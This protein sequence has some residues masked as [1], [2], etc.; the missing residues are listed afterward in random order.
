MLNLE[1]SKH[2]GVPLNEHYR[3]ERCYAESIAAYEKLNRQGIQV[4]IGLPTAFVG[5][6][7]NGEPIELRHET[8][9][10]ED[11]LAHAE[12]VPKELEGSIAAA[13]AELINSKVAEFKKTCPCVSCRESREV[14]S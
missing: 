1:C 7:L 14:A 8:S 2:R 6:L 9:D 13:V 10:Y 12:E 11:I 3:C 5:A 4:S